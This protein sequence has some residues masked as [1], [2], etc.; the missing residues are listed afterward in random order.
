MISNTVA[1]TLPQ[2]LDLLFIK[3]FVKQDMHI[4]HPLKRKIF[5]TSYLLTYLLT[6]VFFEELYPIGYYLL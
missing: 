1:P 4:S 5:H 3:N 2:K 6:F